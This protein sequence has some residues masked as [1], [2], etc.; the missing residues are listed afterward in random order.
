MMEIS[1]KILDN[2]EGLS[3]TILVPYEVSPLKNSNININCNEYSHVLISK[4][5]NLIFHI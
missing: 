4:Y 1:Q 3:M 2:D 5:D